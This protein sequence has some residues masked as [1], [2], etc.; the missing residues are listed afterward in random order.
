MA[1]PT[2]GLLIRVAPATRPALIALVGL[3]ILSG[4]AALA[5]A[6]GLA[7]LVTAV[8]TGT[9][10]TAPATVVVVAL[11]V[12]GLLAAGGDYAAHRTGLAC[13]AAVR[14]A[15]LR[16]WLGLPVESRPGPREATT[17]IGD[18]VAAI[19]PYVARY[20]P[21]LVTSIIIPALTL[22]VLAVVDVW[23]ALIVLL[24]L[25][26]LPLFAALIGMH[27][28]DQTRGRMTAM[29]R[30]AG[31]FIDVVQGL[32]TL[33]AYGRAEHQVAV[34][35]EV[36][37]KHRRA[38]VRT[39]RTAFM[40]TAALELLATISVAMVAV[41]VGLRLAYG[42]IDL[43]VGLSAILLAPEA[44]WPIRRVG[45]EFHN[46]AA[47]AEAL[48]DLSADLDGDAGGT[49]AGRARRRA[50]TTTTSTIAA[51]GITYGYP[52]R[53]PALR[54]VTYTTRNLPGL[55]VLTGPSG[56]GKSTLL[57]LLAGLRTPHTGSVSCPA[58][59][60]ASQRPLLISGTVLDNLAL[61]APEVTRE[62]A[63][64]ALLSVGLWSAVHP[65]GGLDAV[66]GDDGFGLSAG[67]RARLAL[68]RAFLSDAPVLL[69]DEPTAHIAEDSVA[70]IRQ[71]LAAQAAQRPVIVATH[72]SELVAV[73][74]EHWQMSIASTTATRPVGSTTPDDVGSARAATEASEDTQPAPDH[75]TAPTSGDGTRGE[76]SAGVEPAIWAAISQ[77]GR[78]R[79]ACVLGGLSVAS[80]V[81]LTATSGWLIV[82]ASF[83]PVVL[84]LLVAI[85]GV[86]TFGL[87]RPLLRYAE[88]VVSHDVALADLSRRRAD[89]FAALVPLTPARLGR[90]SRADFLTALVRD[91]DDVVDE[92][93]RV[94]VPWVAT[95]IASLVAVGVLAWALPLAAAVVAAG[96]LAALAVGEVTSRS[97]QGR[98]HAAVRER[99]KVLAAA[100]T[101]TAQIGAIQAVGGWVPVSTDAEGRRDASAGIS[102]PLPQV[103]V[104]LA[105][106]EE[107]YRRAETGLIQVRCVG[108]AASWAVI[109][110]VTAFVGWLAATSFASGTLSAPW[111]AL[112]ALTPM[113]L[114]E[115]WTAL[116]EIGGAKARARSAQAR[117]NEVLNQPRAV[118]SIS[119]T[120]LTD[121]ATP[122]EVDR[123]SASWSAMPRPRHPSTPGVN[124]P[125]AHHQPGTLDLDRLTLPLLHTGDRVQLTGPNGAGKSTALAVLARDLDPVQGSYRVAGHDTFHLSVDSVRA[126]I[127]VIDDEPHA[128]AGT[129][130][131]NL[132]LADPSASDESIRAALQAVDLTRWLGALPAGLDSLL[133]GLSGGERARLSMARAVLSRRPI[134]LMDEPAAHLDDDTATH[135]VSGV[136]RSVPLD[137]ASPGPEP[138]RAGPTVIAVNHRPQTWTGF[139]TFD[140]TQ[141]DPVDAADD[142]VQESMSP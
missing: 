16:R 135:A 17:L 129:V 96:A 62:A 101:L 4:I 123:I 30:L 126:R 13:T 9:P 78:L 118:S 8:A 116:P 117:L 12:R 89:L 108:V 110:V 3:G 100:T 36:G 47:G 39:L 19:E 61:G 111:A 49:T 79:L 65:R 133:S 107:A 115:S 67:Q 98:Q 120:Q 113:A 80:G 84:T 64:E 31:H 85:V 71:L 56:G 37:D 59:H 5:V 141:N 26:L 68:A 130:R 102:A 124:G 34:V 23:S 11:L 28:R 92:Q 22:A 40:S 82:Q 137:G 29:T 38:T 52:G 2:P 103:L 44:Y 125:D 51:C 99:G 1:R 48:Q 119:D 87:A 54:Q 81:A 20:L 91:L 43:Q 7:W 121:A 57:E 83:Q 18:G 60:L 70:D 106:R 138:V 50:G 105:S 86:R 33:V 104:G 15:V 139:Q 10:I 76:G 41:S 122:V 58:T 90:R 75:T 72:D 127:A 136:C 93:V 140:L 74:D 128:F 63:A 14:A 27:T 35:G 114:A 77:A 132:A 73:A 24:T 66:V 112:V 42:T 88:R 95:V 21:A 32:P 25:P 69:L 134:V 109:A 46:A 55:T 97:E 131:A 94:H 142:V 6:L 53:D 45:A